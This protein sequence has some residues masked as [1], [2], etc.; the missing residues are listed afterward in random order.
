MPP[1]HFACRQSWIPDHMATLEYVTMQFSNA[2]IEFHDGKLPFHCACYSRAPQAVLKWL[3]EQ[4]N[5]LAIHTLTLDTHELALNCYLSSR[6]ISPDWMPEDNAHY[7]SAVTH[8]RCSNHLHCTITINWGS[9]HC[10]W[11]QCMMYL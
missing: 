4:T 6:A 8:G 2:G 10:I 3:L 5:P 11:Q 7:F 1:L 9:C